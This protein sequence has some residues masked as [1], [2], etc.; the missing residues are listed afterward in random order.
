MDLRR[1]RAVGGR[2][3]LATVN[4]SKVFLARRVVS[5]LSADEILEKSDTVMCAAQTLRFGT[6]L[7]VPQRRP[8]EPRAVHTTPTPR[9]VKM[10]SI[11]VRG[12]ERLPRQH[13]SNDCKFRAC[14]RRAPVKS[15][16]SMLAKT[17]CEQ[18]PSSRAPSCASP[19]ARR[20][21]SF[22]NPRREACSSPVSVLLWLSA[23][24]AARSAPPPLARGG[25][26]AGDA[27]AAAVRERRAA[28]RHEG[29]GR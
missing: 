20:P 6:S 24:R 8:C 14:L 2:T 17:R 29:G 4:G 3:L 5:G 1:V 25:G 9:A 18:E 10:A 13:Q 28:L 16:G 23:L 12:H 7:C 15:A 27:V 19:R 11:T 21:L 26:P 22:C